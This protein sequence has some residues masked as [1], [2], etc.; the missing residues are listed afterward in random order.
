MKVVVVFVDV[1]AKVIFVYECR[2]PRK[3][4]HYEFGID[5][6]VDEDDGDDETKHY[7]RFNV[8]WA[9]VV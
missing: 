8:L 4:W 6:V 5:V 1:K 2:I 7:E 9:G 3:S